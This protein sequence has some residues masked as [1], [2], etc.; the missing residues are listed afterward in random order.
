[1]VAASE[2]DLSVHYWANA[3]SLTGNPA[4]TWW[5]GVDV[6]FS[7]VDISSNGDSVIAGA[8]Y[9]SG[10]YFWSG[11][12]GLSG[13]PQ[14]PSWIYTTEIGIH[15]VAINDAGDY[16]AAAQ[17]YMEP[18][19]AY[20]FGRAGDLKW[21]FDLDNPS[22]VVSISGDGGTLAVGTSAA[23]TGYLLSTGYS[24]R[25]GPVGGIVMPTNK[26]EILSPYLALAGLGAAVS[27][28]VVV[29]KRRD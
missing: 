29:K 25:Q 28:V 11:A 16:M 5:G 13:K 19:K 27:A 9:P 10:V 15:D 7:S 8:A 22:L 23:N 14:S 17:S 26:L 18:H 6:S 2:H 21:S 4:S 3:K 24:S 20:F 1:M 12:R